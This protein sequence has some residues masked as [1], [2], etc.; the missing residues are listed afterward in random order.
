MK[1][2]FTWYF[3]ADLDADD[4]SEACT[5]AWKLF[6]KETKPWRQSTRLWKNQLGKPD[7]NI[8]KNL[9]VKV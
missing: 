2:H 8:T 3:K 6:E 9:K 1:Y 5:G 4:P 7:L